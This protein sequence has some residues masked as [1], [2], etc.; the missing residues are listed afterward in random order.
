M[1]TILALATT[2]LTAQLAPASP[3]PERRIQAWLPGEVRCGGEVVAASMWRRP[4]IALVQ[5]SSVPQPVRVSFRIDASGRP[6]S[7]AKSG[8]AYAPYGDDI[9][10]SLAASRFAGSGERSD[11]LVTYTARITS[12]AET[13]TEDLIS[14][15]L[16][17]TNG[18][19][20]RA[21]WSAIYPASAT[22]DDAV[23]PAA[24]NQAFHEFARI[25]GTPGVRD[26]TMFA[27]DLNAKGKPVEVRVLTGTGNRALGTAGAA[28]L[29]QSRY[30]GGPRTGC[31][32]PYWKAAEIMPAPELAPSDAA[33][34]E[35]AACKSAWAV[36]PPLS[37][38]DP[39]RKRSIEGW[40][41]I[42]FDVAPWGDTGNVRVL[43]SEPAAD[44]GERA[45]AMIRSAKREPSTTG[46]TGCTERVRFR[47][48]RPAVDPENAMVGS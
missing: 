16:N 13:P 36:R 14:Y 19:L 5:G 32:Y 7:I 29:T 40:A 6:L 2:S 21:G 4:Y 26:W 46:V 25:A 28:A 11:C 37:Y 34:E 27:Y 9:A 12:F 35:P 33:A 45:A 47:M 24:L 10:P 41:I 15:T 17:P 39:Y 20:P 8:S 43:A 18:P 42:G 31:R 38:P 44:F 48:G 23:R 3:V 1:L 30:T 22:C